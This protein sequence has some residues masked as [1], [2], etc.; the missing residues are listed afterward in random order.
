MPASVVKL[1]PSIVSIFETC[2]K[3]NALIDKTA[4]L[5]R[6]GIAVELKIPPVILLMVASPLFAEPNVSFPTVKIECTPLNVPPLIVP[7]PVLFLRLFAPGVT[8]TRT[9]EK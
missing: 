2:P 4:S 5:G 3:N 7:M 6:S 8:Y 1:P 9:P